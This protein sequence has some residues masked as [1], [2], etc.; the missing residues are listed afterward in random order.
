MSFQAGEIIVRED[1]TYPE[2]ALIVDGLDGEG[3]LLAHPL[4]GGL[5]RVISAA[6]LKRFS[7]A[8]D[9]ERT[10]VFWHTWFS[11]EGIAERFAGWSDGEHWNG[12]A[13]P[14]FEFA[15]AKRVVAAFDPESGRYDE[16][17]DAF[18]TG[19]AEDREEVWPAAIIHLPDG[20]TAKVYPI[21]ASSWTWD[22]DNGE[23]GSPPWA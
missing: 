20:G 11:L 2:G 16:E 12:W 14:R 18:V 22:A 5:Q 17:A 9:L 4:G 13:K 3:N 15:E 19:T 8:S 1:A 7:I 23:E 21:G 6:E 10:Q